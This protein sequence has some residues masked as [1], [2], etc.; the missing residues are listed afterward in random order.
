RV[1]VHRD[2]GGAIDEEDD[3]AGRRAAAG[4][5]RGHR[6]REG[7]DLA[8]H[9]R[10]ERRGQRR[11][12]AGL[13]GEQVER[14]RGARQEGA[15]AVGGGGDHVRAR[16]QYRDRQRRHARGVDGH[17]AQGDAVVLER[18][19][20]GRRAAARGGGGHGGGQGDRL[21]DDRG[22]DRRHHRGHGAGLVDLLVQGG[23][24]A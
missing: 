15:V 7:G 22:V 10:V 2:R 1:Q 14:G 24:G 3:R 23:R 12:G 4:D 21:A 13:D 9:G 6:R 20:A 8:D 19:G 18:D 17:G 16:G 11:R 5:R